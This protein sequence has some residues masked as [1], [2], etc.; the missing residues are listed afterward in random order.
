MPA[1]ERDGGVELHWHSSGE[2]PAVVI[3][4]NVFSIPEALD[5]VEADLVRDHTVV[6][7]DPRGSGRSTRQGPFDL[8]TDVADLSA[9]LEAADVGPAVAVGPAN[10]VLIATLCATRR[11][12]LVGW[13]IGPTGVPV[14]T[15]Q[16]GQGL[17]ASRE[18]LASIGTQ[19]ATDYRGVI[20]SITV[21]GNSQ[22]TDEQ[23]RQRVEQQIAYCPEETALGRWEAY[24]HADTTE[25]AAALGDRLWILLHPNM[26]W[27]PVEQADPLRELLPEAHI[28]VVEDG[29]LSRPDILAG[30]ARGITA[31]KP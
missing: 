3:C 24:H 23:A 11:P 12:D 21:T 7:Y 8:D 25:E 2:G 19:M 30:V 15:L 29:P 9:I 28:E 31:G 4:D 5:P 18:V 22:F 1:V 26:P 16:L 13:V 17:A 27:W 20:R 14:A 6:R 10:G